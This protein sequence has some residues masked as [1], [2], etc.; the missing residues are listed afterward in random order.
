MAAEAKEEKHASD[1]VDPRALTAEDRHKIKQEIEEMKFNDQIRYRGFDLSRKIRHG[2]S[3][4]YA[5]SVW[6][7]LEK[8]VMFGNHPAEIV[9]V[10]RQNQPN[11][12][13]HQNNPWINVKFMHYFPIIFAK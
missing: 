11:K 4:T 9:L 1:V 8:R 2:S 6:I 12:K 5:G 13:L 10:P 3:F 7:F